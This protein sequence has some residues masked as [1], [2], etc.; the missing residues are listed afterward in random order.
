MLIFKSRSP[1][2]ASVMVVLGVTLAVSIL[3]LLL[4]DRKY[5]L[6][7]GGF[8]QSRA[9]DRSSEIVAFTV[10]YGTSQLLLALAIWWF[11][12]GLTRKQPRWF[13]LLL[14]T[15][16]MGGGFTLALALQYQLHSYFSDA[17]SFALI[18]QLGGGSLLDALLFGLNEIGVGLIAIG[19]GLTLTWMVWKWLKSRFPADSG[20]PY[21]T[22]KRLF[23][24][25]ALS[26]LA[27]AAIVPRLGDDTAYGL[28]RALAW[29]A[30]SGSLDSLTD[31]DGDGYGLFGILHDDYP[32]DAARHPFSFSV[33][34]NRI[35]VD[36]FGADLV[37]EQIP[38]PRVET[39]LPEGA[40]NLVFVVMESARSD[41]LGKRVDGKIVAPN[42]EAMAASGSAAVPSY[43]HVGF[44]TNS[45]KSI[46]SGQLEPQ[47]GDPSLF[48]DLKASGYRIGIFSG[49]PESFG[50]ISAALQMRESA[51]VYVDAE[52][53]KEKRAFSFAAK[54][55]LLVDEKFLL[56]AFEEEF[57][58]AEK[59]KQPVFLYFN[60]QSPHFPYDHPEV[61]ARILDKPIP[62]D[63]ISKENQDWLARTYWNAV[64][65]SDHW[66]GVLVT[67]LKQ[68][69]VW[70]NTI[71]F[72]SG[73]HGE[74]LFEGGFLGHGHMINHYQST[75]FFVASRPRVVPRGPISI[76]D[77]RSTVLD[78][79]AGRPY[80]ETAR[81]AFM[82]IG[83]LNKPTQIGIADSD[84][85]LTTL[86]FDTHEVCFVEKRTCRPN[87]LV[88]GED[89][90]R[91]D[92]LIQRWVS[93]RWAS[94]TKG[95]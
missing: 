27:L 67:R 51:D 39:L 77:Y 19:G 26:V 76:S 44:T 18:R 14:F 59:W 50:D 68:I 10:G 31:F 94:Q 60:F 48:R 29:K 52:T 46:F 56:D 47:A 81:P 61:E 8:G 53:L 78:A 57:G 35:D 73:D 37:I 55:S 83:S 1:E 30:M 74:E 6:F 28:G 62:R 86:R 71:L 40:P 79:L 91:V 84:D 9:V 23:L 4:I 80:Q 93:E 2:K 64:A 69:G 87:H 32:F 21:S 22:P 36:G 3:E 88:I 89:R 7:S 25:T 63:S 72:V 49:Q 90:R 65:N 41:T 54:G 43:S 17:V 58:L 75:T 70:D 34:E 20:R 33:T 42:L 38:A 45:L 95:K 12:A 92:A 16:L 66:L 15:V 24:L 85:R 11:V 5:G 13:A 82:Y